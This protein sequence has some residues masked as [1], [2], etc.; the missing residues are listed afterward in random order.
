M[1]KPRKDNKVK[2]KRG[3]K[4]VFRADQQEAEVLEKEAQVQSNPFED[5]AKSKRARRDADAR[6]G[7]IQEYQDRSRTSQFIDKRI[8]EKS[9]NMTE[10]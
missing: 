4:F 3:K 8:G 6:E 1:A 2:R 9:K 5:H 7:L 10:E